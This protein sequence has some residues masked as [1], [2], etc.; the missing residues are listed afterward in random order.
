MTSKDLLLVVI[1]FCILW[2]TCFTSWA[3]YYVIMILR[4]VYEIFGDMKR[5][6]EA[7]DHFVRTVTEKLD[8]SSAALHLLVEGFNRVTTYIE[9]KK[10]KR[11][12]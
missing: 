7:I 1:A 6:I 12:K 8:H 9:N 4:S 3:L 10:E 2:L 11:R 5:R